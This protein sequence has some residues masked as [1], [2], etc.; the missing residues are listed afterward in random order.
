M[1]YY[2]DV[3]NWH[4]QCRINRVLF[5]EMDKAAMNHVRSGIRFDPDYSQA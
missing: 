3:V 4:H 2:F 1:S 5:L